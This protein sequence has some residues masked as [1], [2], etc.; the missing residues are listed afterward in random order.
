MSSIMKKNVFLCGFPQQLENSDGM[1]CEN[2]NV[3]KFKVR[4]AVIADIFVV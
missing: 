1:E 3:R 4:M 2:E